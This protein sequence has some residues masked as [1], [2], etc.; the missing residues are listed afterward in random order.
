MIQFD[1]HG[2]RRR[3]EEAVVT[4]QKLLHSTR[5]PTFAE[6]VPNH[7]YQ[8]KY[9]LAEF[10]TNCGLAAQCTCLEAL[11]VGTQQ[12]ATLVEWSAS[13]TVT[14][15]LA[16]RQRCT[17]L[18][19]EEREVEST[20]KV[21]KESTI[22]GKSEQKVV[23]RV[24]EWFWKIDVEWELVAYAGTMGGPR[25]LRLQGRSGSAQLKT[26]TSATPEPAGQVEF[27]PTEVPITW[28]LQQ[29]KLPGG[30]VGAAHVLSFKIDRDAEGCRTPRR[31]PQVEAALHAAR[32]LCAWSKRVCQFMNQRIFSKA[33]RCAK[34]QAHTGRDGFLALIASTHQPSELFVPVLPLF[35]ARPAEEEADAAGGDGDG[36]D[37]DGTLV[38][39]TAAAAEAAS[40]PVLRIGDINAMLA[41][42]R[43]ALEAK[44]ATLADAC[45][46][47][48]DGSLL[49]PVELKL[50]I[51]VKHLDDCC[52]QLSQG[53]DYI[54]AML[55]KQLLDAVGR[56]VTPADFQRYMDFH[57]QRLFKPEYAPKPFCFAVRRPDHYPEGTLTIEHLSPDRSR[58]AIHTSGAIHTIC[59]RVAE[60]V[61]PMS[62]ALDAAT[63]VSF[64]G[65]RFVHAYLAHQFGDPPSP[66]PSPPPPNWRSP[67]APCT[68]SGASVLMLGARARQFSS[69]MLLLGRM[70]PAGTFEQKHALI[71]QNKDAVDIPLMLEA[72]PSATEFRDAISSLSPEQQRFAKAYRAM[73][74]EGSVFGILVIQ[75]KPQLEA[76]LK[77]PHDALTKEIALTQQLLDLFIQ[78]QIPSDLLTYAGPAAASPEEKLEAVRGHVAAIYKMV[79]AAKEGELHAAR[80]QAMM[81][82]PFHE[83][84]ESFGDTSA[85]FSLFQCG[86]ASAMS[87]S[88]PDSPPRRN[89]RSIQRTASSA[90]AAPPPRHSAA[91]K[92]VRMPVAACAA[93][94]APPGCGPPPPPGASFP[95]PTAKATD[96]PFAA[97]PPPPFAP[98]QKAAAPGAAAG[99]AAPAPIAG[100]AEAK[101]NDDDFDTADDVASELDYTKI[102]STL[103]A[104]LLTAE[105]GAAIRPTTIKVG[106]TWTKRSQKALLGK[107]K[108]E[109]LHT[110]EQQ[111]EKQ[112]AFDLLDALSCSGALPIACCSLHV[113]VAA[114]HA[115]DQSLLDTVIQQNVNPIEKLERSSLLV[116]TTI[117]DAPAGRLLRDEMRERV[118]RFAAPEL[119]GGDAAAAGEG[120]VADLP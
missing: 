51:A 95:A 6:D 8:D 18:R 31:N 59:R 24:N 106:E 34:V 101:A 76:L 12:L 98:G 55:K 40:T 94:A 118:A 99:D 77:L 82:Q 113:V 37:G 4:L 70:G 111:R 102:P 109:A 35:E 96:G 36:G 91:Q 87:A 9:L 79:E 117:H 89:A 57:G 1:E 50:S 80:Q 13:E 28:L 104:K 105:G 64:T 32:E 46:P 119:L 45:P 100:P 69:F 67:P 17:F 29:V 7:S 86:D 97:A 10:L 66:P 72:L 43:R 47:A 103:D 115:F 83:Y 116:A 61:A 3:V 25:Q 33:E 39:V 30:L 54:E 85:G 21:V 93:G 20:S 90:S 63:R 14:L 68:S 112:A 48:D 73:Q 108:E 92:R 120:A 52:S 60:P 75:L 19:E 15:R 27:I 56:L 5:R 49:S 11:G 42:Q 78:Y 114:T 81:E 107:P 53:V 41:E 16:G 62:F 22:F 2:F 38:S 110:E 58:G 84:A 74:L 26:T 65:E 88:P 23:T 44:W 71:L